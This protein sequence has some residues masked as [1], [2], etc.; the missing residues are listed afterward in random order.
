MQLDRKLS[1]IV[2]SYLIGHVQEEAS[3]FLGS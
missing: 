2:L 1:H 3:V